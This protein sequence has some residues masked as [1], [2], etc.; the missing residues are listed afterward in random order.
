MKY[1]T[2]VTSME[3]YTKILI[4]PDRAAQIALDIFDIRGE[5]SSLPGEIDFN[6]KISTPRNESFIL[7]ISRPQECDAYLDFQ[8]QL[9]DYIATN[10]L[11]FA[12][13]PRVIRA[14]NGEAISEM[15]DDFGEVRKVRMLTWID[16]RIW[17]TVNPQSASL[18]YQLGQQCGKLTKL[19]HG[20]THPEASRTFEWDI[21]QAE[22]TYSYGYYFKGEQSRITSFF[23]R[24][25]KENEDTYSQLRKSVVH[26]DANDNNIIVSKDLLNPSVQTCIDFG[27]AVYTQIIN[28]VAVACTYAI[29]KH[30]NPLEAA[31]P[32][33][34]GY[35]ESF[36]LLEEELAHLYTAIGM[37][38]VISVT[39]SAINKEREPTNEYLCISE[40]GAWELLQKWYAID[41]EYAHVCFRKICGFSAH[42][43]EQQFVKWAEQQSFSLHS[44]FPSISFTEVMGIDL[45]VS[46]KWLG[47]KE[48]FLNDDFIEYKLKTLQKQNPDKLIAGGY[49]EP[50]PFYSS[51]IYER[52][53]NKGKEHRTVHLG[54]DF[55]LS[56]KT[57][58]HCFLEG[59]VVVATIDKGEKGY[60]GLI[61]LE[62]QLETFTFYS[63]YGH[64]SESSVQYLKCGDVLNVGDY[65]GSL[66]AISENGGWIPHLHFQLMLSMLTYENDFPG[67]TYPS[68]RIF[69]S[70]ICPDP[71]LIFKME[72]LNQYLD[73]ANQELISYRKMHLGKSLSLQYKEPIKMVR[74]DGVFLMDQY[75]RQYLDTVNNVAHVGHEHPKVVKAGQESN[76][77]N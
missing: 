28:D 20:F 42:T 27:D 14:I 5:A 43:N 46:S 58:V 13:V 54:I 50:R 69:W 12:K 44:L 61:I 49:L 53:G 6:F 37:R 65:I 73:P 32:I 35:H 52:T 60:G 51:A 36:P 16:G 9:L 17:S 72:G 18:R 29:M 23:Q 3:D 15:K 25:F 74:G 31:L 47:H 76:G 66:G 63:L 22:W 55:W 11:E 62:H 30:A 38:L 1:Q 4:T 64:L 45:S 39:K 57:P 68:E 10:A 67:V 75:G 34:Q 33:V 24:L 71:N 56:E 7:K 8:Q 70:S 77:L 59:K 19:L 2:K 26:N 21:A 41:R 40:K 48:D